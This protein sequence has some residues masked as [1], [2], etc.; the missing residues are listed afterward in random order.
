MGRRTVGRMTVGAR[1]LKPV[2]RKVQDGRV[3]SQGGPSGSDVDHVPNLVEGDRIQ[4][5]GV[6]FT[7]AASTPKVLVLTPTKG[8]QI[9][10]ARK[11]MVG[12]RVVAKVE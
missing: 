8:L 12:A 3:V 7:V 11:D 10:M 4:F 6:F 5:R 2:N 1:T 9:T